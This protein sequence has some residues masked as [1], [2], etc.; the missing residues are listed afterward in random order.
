[1]E[2]NAEALDLDEHL[3]ASLESNEQTEGNPIID[4]TV[5]ESSDNYTE[6]SAVLDTVLFNKGIYDINKIK[7]SDD[8]D[9]LIERPWSELTTEE[10]INI[11]SHSD[12]VQSQNNYSDL[13]EEEAEFIKQIREHNYTPS[14]YVQVIRSM[15]SNNNSDDTYQIDS[16][17]D[18]QLFVLD[19]LDKYGE[20]NITDEELGTLLNNAKQDPELYSK[21][22]DALRSYYKNKEDAYL[23]QQQQE[24]AK[25]REQEYQDFSES[26]LR[27]IQ[28]FNNVSGRAIELSTNDMNDL[29]NY[30]LTRDEFGNSEFAKD[31]QNP[32]KF[33]QM[34]FWALKGNDIMNEISSQLKMAYDQG[35]EAGKKS[36][37]QLVI[38]NSNVDNTTHNNARYS[39]AGEL[40]VF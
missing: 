23:Y 16:I 9:T 40:D 12:D 36:H 4:N 21:T 32:Q 28:S 25:Q 39:S 29:A 14:Q 17:D 18:D 20:D 5:S 2:T 15:S 33:T 35:V 13:T 8:N 38:N 19:L 10:K 1:M 11:L 3:E 26:V 24:Q 30:L 34:A 31:L 7:F 27:E 37:S 6:E 22:I